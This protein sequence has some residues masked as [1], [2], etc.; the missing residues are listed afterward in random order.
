MDYVTL[1]KMM[2]LPEES[3]FSLCKLLCCGQITFPCIGQ[4]NACQRIVTAVVGIVV[5]GGYYCRRL[6]AD[7][8][9][10]DNSSCCFLGSGL[11]VDDRNFMKVTITAK[12]N[13][14]II[15]ITLTTEDASFIAVI[16]FENSDVW[17]GW[18]ITKDSRASH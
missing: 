15:A 12:T 5:D 4:H 9:K 13:S 10:C 14:I 2:A 17:S 7:W 3:N 1:A 16:K 8:G 11:V 18:F 6:I